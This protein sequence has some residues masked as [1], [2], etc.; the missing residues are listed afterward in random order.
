MYTFESSLP[1]TTAFRP[2]TLKHANKQ[3]VE[4]VCPLYVLTHFDVWVFQ[5]RI[6][7]S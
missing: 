3:Y 1:L 4:F 6:V 7:E 2:V 5:S